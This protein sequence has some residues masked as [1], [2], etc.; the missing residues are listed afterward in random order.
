LPRPETPGE[1]VTFLIVVAAV[2]GASAPVVARTPTFDVV[3][4]AETRVK[5]GPEIHAP[6]VE[7]A[8]V[9]LDELAA[10]ENFSVTYVD[11]P[12]GFTD[13]FLQRFE[14]ILQ[15]NYTPF[16]WNP[17]ARAA[18]QKYIEEGRGGWVGLH[19]ALLFGPV[20]TPRSETPWTW[21]YEF[22]GQINFAAYIKDFAQGTVHVETPEHPIFAGVPRSF[23]VAKDEWY[24]WD[25]SPRPHVRVLANVDESSYQPPSQIKMGDHPVIWTNEKYKARN[26]F[27]F[28]G[29]HPDHFQNAAYRTL[30]RNCILWA[31][32][33]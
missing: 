18:F 13:A 26:V 23:A 22:I 15:L 16:R 17:S 4:I 28:M 6:F 32:K 11:D 30:L 8:K 21:F 20:V 27:L 7:R 33:K 1:T 10:A 24:T 3:A 2:I 9:W 12:N 14:L 5:G 25:R 19:H 29:H 31:A